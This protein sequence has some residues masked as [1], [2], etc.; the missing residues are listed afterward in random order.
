MCFDNKLK[1]LDVWTGVCLTF[2]FGALLEF[3]EDL[4]KKLHPKN[5]C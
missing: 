1:A 4:K 2:V 5:S 3:G